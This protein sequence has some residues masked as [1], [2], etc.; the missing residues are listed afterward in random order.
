MWEIAGFVISIAALVVSV[1]AIIVSVVFYCKSAKA[2]QHAIDILAAYLQ[3]MTE[4]GD[5]KVNWDKKGHAVNLNY[6][7]HID[8][9]PSQEQV[10]DNAT[11]RAVPKKQ[12]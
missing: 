11:V 6:T 10:P 9:I 12:D 3:G 1:V 2:L 8:G 4:G 7:L 5:I